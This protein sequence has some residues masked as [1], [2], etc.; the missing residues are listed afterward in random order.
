MAAYKA[1]MELHLSKQHLQREGH[2]EEE[3]E[4]ESSQALL[5]GGRELPSW[6]LSFDGFQRF[7][8]S[9]AQDR[10]SPVHSYTCAFHDCLKRL[11][12]SQPLTTH[13]I[14]GVSVCVCVF[15][16]TLFA[17]PFLQLLMKKHLLCVSICACLRACVGF[18]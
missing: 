13:I 12:Q 6:R 18:F 16:S 11:G 17:S 15:L 14:D 8:S 4:E 10:A 2:G 7:S 3:E 5:A 9:A 1:E